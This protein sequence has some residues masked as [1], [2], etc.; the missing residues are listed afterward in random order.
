MTAEQKRKKSGMVEERL[1]CAT[2][3]GKCAPLREKRAGGKKTS[4]PSSGKTRG[5]GRNREDDVFRG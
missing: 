1:L 4:V 2:E 3:R 5:R